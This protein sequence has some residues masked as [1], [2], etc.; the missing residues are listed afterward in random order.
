MSVSTDTFNDSQRILACLAACEKIPTEVLEGNR[1]TDMWLALRDVVLADD[2][3]DEEALE[4][5][6]EACRAILTRP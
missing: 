3:G 1:I 5:A 4:Y 6:I 2:E